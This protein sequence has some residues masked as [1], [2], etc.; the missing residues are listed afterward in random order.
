[1][2]DAHGGA[3]AAKTN[4][5]V[6]VGGTKSSYPLIYN[7]VSRTPGVKKKIAGLPKPLLRVRLQK[8]TVTLFTIMAAETSGVGEYPNI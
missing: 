6:P 1:M 4:P 2:R 7:I 8:G 3:A 5:T